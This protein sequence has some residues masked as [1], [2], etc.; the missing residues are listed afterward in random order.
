MLAA[1]AAEGWH[2]RGCAQVLILGAANILLPD[3][4]KQFAHWH[5]SGAQQ[6]PMPVVENVHK[7][8]KAA[9][10]VLV[11]A[12]EPGNASE[13]DHIELLAESNVFIRAYRPDAQLLVCELRGAHGASCPHA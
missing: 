13:D 7:R 10:C 11:G 2:A 3:G 1:A 9:R 12:G 6:L 5:I 8:S 4:L